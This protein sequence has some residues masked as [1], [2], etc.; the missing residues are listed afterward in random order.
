MYVVFLSSLEDVARGVK[1]CILCIVSL[2]EPAVDLSTF[3]VVAEADLLAAARTRTE[4]KETEE[5]VVVLEPAHTAKQE[6]LEGFVMASGDV[7]DP[8]LEDIIVAQACKG[9]QVGS[10]LVR[11]LLTHARLSKAPL[12]DLYCKPELLPFYARFGFVD[13]R[14]EINNKMLLRW[15]RNSPLNPIPKGARW[16]KV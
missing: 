13:H 2:A 16:G 9:K 8:L 10:K 5:K 4:G 11:G 6:V 14:G 1:S 15:A 3:G 7:N 12:V